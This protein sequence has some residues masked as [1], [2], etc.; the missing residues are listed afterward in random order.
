LRLQLAQV[1]TALDVAEK[2]GRDKD[3]QIVSLG[4]RLNTALAAKVEELQRYRSEFFGRLRTVLADRPGVQ[5]VGDRFVFQ[6]E[7]LFPVGSA[8][9]TPGGQ[10]QINA[11]ATTLHQIATE[12]PPD[13]PWML[14]VDGHADRQ[15]VVG[16]NFASNWELSAQR[17]INVAKL[18]IADGVPAN[19]V[20]ATAFSDNQPLA[21]GDTPE[22][23]TRNRRIELRLT[24]R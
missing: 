15:K 21:N 10:D 23:Y 8:D 13:L 7:V 2:S 12:I 1:A 6:S 24:D 17:A 22:D 9:M 16:G 20:A 18:L 11:L 5:I 19:H 3:A 14:R 4:Q